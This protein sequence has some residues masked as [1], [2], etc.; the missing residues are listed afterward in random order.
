MVNLVIDG[1]HVSVQEGTT[2]LEAAR[3]ININ[4]P[5]LCY[6]KEIN[7]IAACR[8]CCVEVEGERAMVASCNTPVREG[9]VVKTNSPRVRATRRTNVEL[10]LSQ[11]SCRCTTCVRSGSCQLQKLANDL[12]IVVI[13]YEPQ[14][15]EG[16]RGAWTT[17]FPLMHDH[18]KCIK[19]MRCI[20]ICNKVQS[21]GIWDLN[22]TGGRT[23]V[24][25]SF[26]RVIKESD[27]ALCGQC[28]THCPVGG[29]RARSDTKIAFKALA[30]PDKITIVF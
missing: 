6:L 11:H 30:D 20:Q 24:D 19:C 17:T 23:T 4:I 8:V 28:I 3:Q 16:L 27:C 25:V 29:L 21:L 1:K 5:H 12:G 10:I 18:N 22:G 9:M 2:I 15:V 14:L 7:E 13:P 26:N